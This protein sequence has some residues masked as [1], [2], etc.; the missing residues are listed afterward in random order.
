M[1]DIPI[2]MRWEGD[3]FV[4]ASAYWAKRADQQYVIGEVYNLAPVEDR[5]DKTH[6]HEFAWLREAW[7]N[8]PEHLADQYPTPEHLRKRALIDTGWYDEEIIDCGTTAA[9]IRVASSFRR[10]DDFVVVVV[11]GPIVVCRTAKSQSRRAMDRQQFQASKTAIMDA[12]AAL[13]GTTSEAL[14]R[15]Q[16][17]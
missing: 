14:Q 2:P 3:G 4:P 9:A 16:A 17:A 6:R 10:R 8:L 12:I 15:E 5:S 7:L 1:T 11:R 13:I